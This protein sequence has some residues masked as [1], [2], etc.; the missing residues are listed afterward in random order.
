MNV[1]HAFGFSNELDTLWR[2]HY[3]LLLST[4]KSHVVCP[5]CPICNCLTLPSAPELS[6]VSTMLIPRYLLTLRSPYQAQPHHETATISEAPSFSLSPM[7]TS[8]AGAQPRHPAYHSPHPPYSHLLHYHYLIRQKSLPATNPIGALFIRASPISFTHAATNSTAISRQTGE[9]ISNA[10]A[11]G[12]PRLSKLHRTSRT[13]QSD[14]RRGVN[15]SVNESRFGAGMMMRA[16]VRLGQGRGL[17]VGRART[18]GGGNGVGGLTVR[19]IRFGMGIAC[20]VM[21][22]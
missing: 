6:T 19:W 22:R 13:M 1:F 15:G 2:I 11:E 4:S 16:C 3:F 8:S 7:Q 12:P 14:G 20:C 17:G 18:R 21:S 10:A 5:I 9:T